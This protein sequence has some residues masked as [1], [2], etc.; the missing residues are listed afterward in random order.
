MDLCVNLHRSPG[1]LHY[2]TMRLV[3]ARS[4]VKQADDDDEEEEEE[5]D[6]DED[7]DEDEDEEED[8]EELAAV[9][10][11]RAAEEAVAKKLQALHA[12][13]D[14]VQLVLFISLPACCHLRV[15][16]EGLIR[17]LQENHKI[18]FWKAF[19]TC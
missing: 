17:D 11:Q 10:A 3:Q 5:D 6:D 14:T 16:K 9:A 18:A 15:Y 2:L 8:E 12:S 19:L 13:D 4:M 7:D 1:H